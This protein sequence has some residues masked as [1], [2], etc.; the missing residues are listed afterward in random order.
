MMSEEQGIQGAFLELLV[1][2]LGSN[3]EFC[4]IVSCILGRGNHIHKCMYAQNWHTDGA[5]NLYVRKM[6]KIKYIDNLY[7]IVYLSDGNT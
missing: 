5:H 6:R 3:D 1:S 7:D 4:I 2:A